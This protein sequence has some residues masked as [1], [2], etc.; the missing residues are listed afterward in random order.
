MTDDQRCQI[1]NLRKAGNGYKRISQI[2]GVNEST[3][4]SFCKRRNLG[5]V[6]AQSPESSHICKYCGKAVAQNLGRKEKKFCSDI[7]RMKWWNSHLD[8]VNRKTKYDFTC[9]GCKKSFT[10]FGNSKRKYCS[11]ACYIA[12]R[13]SS[14]KNESSQ[15]HAKTNSDST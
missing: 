6:K 11:H 14:D 1:V 13:F 15:F 3:V 9:A 4:K 2:V 12:T 10:V 5:G 7:C 8:L